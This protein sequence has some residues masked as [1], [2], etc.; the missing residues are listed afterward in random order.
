MSIRKRLLLLVFA[1]W[2]PAAAGFALFTWYTHQEKTAATRRQIEEYGLRLSTTLERELDKRVVL[3][4]TLA[5]SSEARNGDFAR[6][7]EEALSATVGRDDW[8]LLVD[9]G[10]QIFN[11][12]APYPAPRVAR[13]KPLAL[14][15]KDP[16][17]VFVPSAPVA[18]TPAITVFVPVL[19]MAPQEYN[20]GVSFQP[21]DL[22]RILE[23]NPG[24]FNA[25]TAVVN[26]EQVIMGRSRDPGK[27]F[28][29]S[30]SEPFKKR[31]LGG[32]IGF[33]ESSTLD[34]VRSMTYLSPPSAYGWSVVVSVPLSQLEGA[35][36]QATAK[37]VGAAAFLLAFG[38]I[39]AL[40]GTRKIGRTLDALEKA[41]S[42]LG[43]HRVPPRLATGMPEVDRVGA[44]LHEAGRQA[45][46]FNETM[47]RRVTDAVR[48]TQEAHL[49]LAH[50]QKLEL[51][52]RLTAGV[53]HD[54]NNL[55]QTIVTAHHLLLR[56]VVDGAERRALDGAVRAVA[57]ARDLIKQLMTFGR[58]QALVPA[59][60]SIADI[61]LKSQ[62]LTRTAV[63]EA[64][65][66]T[67]DVEPELPL[68]H[69]D[70]VQLEMA[71]LNLVFNSRDAMPGGGRIGIAAS[72]A[73]FAETEHL[74]PGRF[75]RLEVVDNGSGMTEEVRAQAFDP[76]FTTKPVGAG[77]GIGLAQVHSFAKQSGGDVLL[78]SASGEGTRI[79]LYLPVASGEA[80]GEPAAPAAPPTPPASGVRVL[81][82]ED[83]KMVASMIATALDEEGYAV[84]HCTTADEAVA[85]LEGGK[86]FDILFTDV[87][88]PGRMNGMALA[89]WCSKSRPELAIVVTTGYAENLDEVAQVVLRKPY[90]TAALFATLEQAS[91]EA[92]RKSGR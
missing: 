58:V 51:V 34:G 68:V 1:V 49:R 65:V 23:L 10:W 59:T 43:H 8:V 53:A 39:V 88:M 56:R 89:K 30:A 57:K 13:A 81:M 62:E 29:V 72:E 5:S 41:A 69:V 55:L 42:D 52:G 80:P 24:P 18:R 48:E 15:E 79:R 31:I 82:V 7:H 16:L 36:E 12:K 44:A 50:S 11:T 75:V 4:Q 45:Q 27:W 60:V 20:V 74:G 3:A 86:P 38:F 76:F 61:V 73:P 63:G 77:T 21:T 19:G 84:D 91:R 66:L 35:S 78:T 32:G 28:G 54:F 17:I 46:L 47:E 22:Q 2:L 40:T 85:L 26:N 6:F 71:L 33:A 83:D 87:V 70:P 14:T 25:L 92:Q 9:T 37:A 67:T 90:D 64:I